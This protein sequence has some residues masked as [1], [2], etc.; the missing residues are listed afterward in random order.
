MKIYL[1]C[2]PCV[3]SYYDGHPTKIAFTTKDEAWA[4]C[5]KHNGPPDDEDSYKHAFDLYFT[6]VEVQD[7]NTSKSATI[8]DLASPA[9]IKSA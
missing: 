2:T 6:E 8:D 4:H 7:E 1:I 3:D 9:E 5:F